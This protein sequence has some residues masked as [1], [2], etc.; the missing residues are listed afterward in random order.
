MRKALRIASR[1]AAGSSCSGCPQPHVALQDELAPEY[2]QLN[3]LKLTQHDTC[4]DGQQ[5][6]PHTLSA[7]SS[8]EGSLSA[9]TARGCKFCHHRAE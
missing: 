3:A 7:L 2:S 8:A 1:T 4:T 5:C 6:M 9:S